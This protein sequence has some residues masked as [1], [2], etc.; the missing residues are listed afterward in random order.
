MAMNVGYYF[1]V[2]AVFDD[3]VA[4]IP[5]H[6]AMFVRGLAA[7]AGS[8]TFYA[9]SAA[10]DG[11]ETDRLE[12]PNIRCVNLGCRRNA[13]FR[14]FLPALSLRSFRPRRDGV[15]A[16]IVRSPTPLM[17][18][19]IRRCKSDGVAVLPMFVADL[20]KWRPSRS[21]PRWRNAL[22][23]WFFAKRH[24]AQIERVI[25]TMPTAAISRAIYEGHEVF[26]GNV[27]FTAT[28]TD[29]DLARFGTQRPRWP[30]G[31]GANQPLRLLFTGRFAE[32]KGL[33]E[34]VDALRLLRDSGVD[35]ELE[36][37]GYASADRTIGNLLEDATAK[38]VRDAMVVT[39]FIPAGPSLLSKYR[40]A[41]IYVLPT[42]AEG[43][44]PRTIKE[45]LS[46]RMPIIT[47]GIPHIAEYLTHEQEALFI[48][49]NSPVAIADA[50]KRLLADEELARSVADRG[51][52]WARHLT[53]ERSVRRVLDVLQQSVL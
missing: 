14:V 46:T 25:R 9:H 37:V 13:P 47:T 44:V 53:N 27:V 52:E 12:E 49:M 40:D 48:E 16:M 31:L 42:H 7:H 21:M 17:A 2:A 15:D 30:E 43:S 39:G 41:H 10:G 32:E 11:T 33:F 1:H 6:Y 34:L 18:G 24:L 4:R 20:R 35:V 28:V 50:V 45:A 23:P 19:M 5:S 26:D 22:M 36:L 29:A 3:G 8:V 51:F 38:G